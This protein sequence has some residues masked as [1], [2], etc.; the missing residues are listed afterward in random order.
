MKDIRP[1][2]EGKPQKVKVKVRINLH[3]IMT[4]SSASLYEAKESTEGENGNVQEVEAG[5]QNHVDQANEQQA[6]AQQQ[7]QQQN[8]T[9]VPMS[10]GTNG[11]PPAEVGSSWT[12]KISAWFSGVGISIPG[13]AGLATFRCSLCCFIFFVV[14]H[15]YT[16]LNKQTG[17][18]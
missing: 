18:G 1:N 11:A 6:P 3:G 9:D 13:N 5:Q 14:T 10:D 15:S 7:Q 12:K 2:A 4:V 16:T 17:T 8:E